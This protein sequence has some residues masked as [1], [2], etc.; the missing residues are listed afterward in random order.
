MGIGAPVKPAIN[1]DPGGNTSTSAPIPAVRARLS[2]SIPR[3]RPTISRISVTSNPTAT[4][5]I[6]ER[7]GLC[8][9]FPTIMRFIIRISTFSYRLPD[10]QRTTCLCHPMRL[11]TWDGADQGARH[12]LPV[13]APVETDH[14][15]VAD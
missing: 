4:T 6:R 15:S 13:A 5:L 8:T 9:R 3:E 12:Q 10:V 7:N 14:R 2:C 1:D 11:P